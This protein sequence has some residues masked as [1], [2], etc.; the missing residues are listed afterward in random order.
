MKSLLFM[1]V[2]SMMATGCGKKT[3]TIV[4][5]PG[6]DGASCYAETRADGNFVV[7]ADSEFKVEDGTDG[8]DG[9]DGID[10]EDGTDGSDGEDGSFE[11]YLDLVELCPEHTPGNKDHIETLL[12]LDGQY[13]AFLSDSNYKKQR[14]TLLN[15]GTQY[16]TTDGR[17]INFVIVGDEIHFTSH[18]G[19]CDNY[20]PAQ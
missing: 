6:T 2:I 8:S 10:G 18:Q 16:K 14:L 12:Y 5:S 13:M 11:G 3:E 17:N 4:S 15:E 20:Q 7:C 19:Q 9:Q 1:L